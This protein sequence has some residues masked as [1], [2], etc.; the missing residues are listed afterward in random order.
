MPSIMV[1]ALGFVWKRNRREKDSFQKPNP[2]FQ[3]RAAEKPQE[4]M[5]TFEKEKLETPKGSMNLG[6]IHERIA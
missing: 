6:T 3:N 5:I 4:E 2:F 1:L